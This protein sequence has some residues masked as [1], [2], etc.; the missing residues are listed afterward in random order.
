VGSIIN[1]MIYKKDSLAQ[2]WAPCAPQQT[3]GAL[4][5]CTGRFM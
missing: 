1:K 3:I 4:S 5:N 2:N